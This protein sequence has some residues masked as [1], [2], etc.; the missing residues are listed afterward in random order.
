MNSKKDISQLNWALEI[1]SDLIKFG[2]NSRRMEDSESCLRV[3]EEFE[4]YEKCSDLILIL[5]HKTPG[6][7][8]KIGKNKKD[9]GE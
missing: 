5:S 8:E 6:M 1:Y 2:T 4:E 3:L 9:G 7:L